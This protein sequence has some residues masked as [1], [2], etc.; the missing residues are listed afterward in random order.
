[1]ELNELIFLGVCAQLPKI[2]VMRVD[3]PS[4]GGGSP[5]FT[6]VE[7]AENNLALNRAVAVW[8]L[9]VEAKL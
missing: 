6:H 3:T 8:A 7:H 9:V 1:M 2:E 4:M 5:K